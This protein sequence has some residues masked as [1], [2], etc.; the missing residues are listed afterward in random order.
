MNNIILIKKYNNIILYKIST[1]IVC[2]AIIINNIIIINILLYI[3]YYN[4]Y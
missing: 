3:E 1:Y 4:D 2:I